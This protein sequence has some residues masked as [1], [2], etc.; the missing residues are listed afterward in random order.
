MKTSTYLLL[1]SSIISFG[2]K[3]QNW[4]LVWQDEF[5]GSSLN[6]QKWI[7]EIGTGSQNGLWGW[8]NGELQYYKPENTTVSNGTLKITAQE[9]PNGI[10][11][12][13]QSWNILNYSSSRIKTDGL[14]SFKYGKVQA[15]MKT[16]D[17]QGFWPAFWMLPSG[18]SWPCDGEIDIMEQWGNDDDTNISTGAAHVGICPYEP[19]AHVYS[20][21]QQPI[22]QGSY[23]DQFHIYEVRWYENFI[24]WY[25]DDVLVYE[26]TPNSYSSQFN[27]PFNDNEWYLIL[28]FAITSSGPN[29]NTILPS[30]IEVDWIRVYQENEL[31]G[32]TNINASNY[33]N[34][35]TFDNGSCTYEVTFQVDL[36]CSSISPNSVNVTSAND[37]WSC[38]GGISLNDTDQ[39]GIWEGT[40]F[41]QEGIFSYIYCGDNWNYNEEIFAYAQSSSDWSCTPNTDYTNY[42]NRQIN[43]NGPLTIYETWGSCEPCASNGETFGCTDPTANNYNHNATIENGSCTYPPTTVEF[44]VDMNGI[45]QPSTDYDNVVINGSWNGWNGWG[46]TLSDQDSD[47]VFTGS[48]EIDP[49]TSF[50]YVVAVTGLADNWSGWGMQWGDGCNNVNVAVTAG[51]AGTVTPSLL[52]PGCTELIGCMDANALNYIADA[53]VQDYDQYGNLQCVYASCDDIPEYGC[54]YEYGFGAFTEFFNAANCSSYGGIPCEETTTDIFGCT[55]EG[56]TNFNIEAT[57]DD[58]SCNFD[59]F[60]EWNVIVTDQNHSIFIN[61]TYLNSDGELLDE[62]TLIGVFYYN[63]NGNFVCAGYT[64]LENEATQISVMGDDA[65][66]V[67][68]DGLTNGDQ[69]EYMI[70]DK[71]TCQEYAASANYSSGIDYY[72]SNGI[73]FIDQ[74]SIN[75]DINSQEIELVQGWSIF[76]T[77]IQ[78]YDPD[79][80]SV[81]NSIAENII[82][83]KDNLGS[84]YLPEWNFNGIGNL[85]NG[86]GY[87]IKMLTQSNLNIDGELLLPENTNINLEVGWNMIAYLRTSPSSCNLV[88]NSLTD[89]D[90]LVIVKDSDGNAYLPEWNFNGIGLMISG[91]GYQL[92]MYVPATFK[93]LSNSENYE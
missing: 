90:Q 64:S 51:D 5:T 59:C 37:N 49:G 34:L 46:V 55:D 85:T 76:S 66:T 14:F 82:I 71:I 69:F 57:I 21:F 67:E 87:Q 75:N 1:L 78:A 35:A 42:A 41:M 16:V 22:D 58:G 18:G 73:S 84:A 61:G 74:I 6:E 19:G 86:Q 32:C 56:A 72:V 9:E 36:S 11:D 4:E 50:E 12:P 92:K 54:I 25:I 65:S 40:S 28:N 80:I 39:D 63:S 24:Q 93:Y 68:I 30:F 77:Y 70:W 53:T 17:G 47:G 10:V 88:F 91:K 43:I 31:S 15:R 45:N 26:I 8:G 3:A 33:N 44:T 29:S 48:L 62:G 81:F 79:L 7:H 60:P 52:T 38:N 27:W 13:F 2:C 89:N 83:I 20:N 23:A